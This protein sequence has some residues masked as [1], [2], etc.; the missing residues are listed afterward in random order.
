MSSGSSSAT[1][2]D[3]FDRESRHDRRRHGRSRHGRSRR[4]HSSAQPLTPGSETAQILLAISGLKS[5]TDAVATRVFGLERREVGTSGVTPVVPSPLP[6]CAEEPAISLLPEMEDPLSSEMEESREWRPQHVDRDSAD[7]TMPLDRA[8]SASTGRTASHGM[9]LRD[10]SLPSERDMEGRR[11]SDT[12]KD[13]YSF[14]PAI[15]RQAPAV[16]NVFGGEL[17]AM[18]HETT[19]EERNPPLPGSGVL[20]S[21]L[22]HTGSMLQGVAHSPLT[23]AGRARE[24][25]QRWGTYMS[26][27][28]PPIRQYKGEFYKIHYDP[29]VPEGEVLQPQQ[30]WS[31]SSFQAIAKGTTPSEFR[32][33]NSLLWDWEGL[34]RSSLGVINHLDWFLSTL[35]KM[36]SSVEVEPEMRTHMDNMLRSSSVAVNQLAHMQAR[37]LAG[38]AAFHREGLLDASVL[39]RAGA[40]FLQSQPI[41]GSDLFGGKVPEA[42]RITSE[43]R[44]KQLL[45]QAPMKPAGRGGGQTGST[46]GLP[47]ASQR[48]GFRKQKAFTPSGATHKRSKPQATLSRR[49]EKGKGAKLGVTTTWSNKPKV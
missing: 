40:M 36:V 1:S 3:E 16:D 6:P 32:I 37:L 8:S 15:V 47:R 17:M 38:N 4:Q 28:T 10:D 49:V 34:E 45:F 11:Y 13:V 27:S 44:S 43:D 7:E 39:D 33:R 48:G 41:G 9:G 21:A 25:A 19:K 18:C 2:Y 14:N 35:W 20:T 5:T 46:R 42:L 22:R 29:E 12:L 31:T 30:L 23:E 26:L 24:G